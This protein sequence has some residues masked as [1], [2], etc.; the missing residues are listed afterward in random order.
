MIDIIAIF[1]GPD[2][3]RRHKFMG[4]LLTV[5]WA[6]VYP[7]RS[8]CEGI[9][10]GL[11]K[12]RRFILYLLLGIS[13]IAIFYIMAPAIGDIRSTDFSIG[14][15]D[16]LLAI[17]FCLLVLLLKAWAHVLILDKYRLP[18]INGWQVVA[19]Y[20]N[21]QVVRYIPGKVFG[22][23]SQSVRM[24]NVARASV[25]WEANVT[26]DLMTNIVSVLVLTTLA[27]CFFLDSLLVALPGV[28]L[29]CLTVPL[30]T[31]NT[32]TRVFN[33]V[34]GLFSIMPVQS[35]RH[36]WRQATLILICLCA[37]W[38]LFFMIWYSLIGGES[39]LFLY[40]GW[41]YAAASWLALLAIVVPS[42]ILVR[43]AVFLWLGSL[44]GLPVEQL[45]FY[46]VVFRI[47]Y[48]ACEIILYMI[49][50]LL[51]VSQLCGKS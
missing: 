14:I 28:L 45:F 50:E 6:E 5:V 19:A 40:I 7:C 24:A 2:D 49:M 38:V 25:V 26:Q 34:A 3:R 30:L 9:M 12:N 29:L 4:P 22:I 39:P 48:T 31:R 37:E 8:A 44:F 13:L 15:T 1:W 21:G 23:I 27:A 11:L 10:M 16:C 20:A 42:G 18:S 36:S 41:F 47:L 43:E 32:L 46:G 51:I 33:Y 17:F 35:R